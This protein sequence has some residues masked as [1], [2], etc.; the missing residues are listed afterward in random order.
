MYTLKY[1]D[2]FSVPQNPRNLVT[3]KEEKDHAISPDETSPR[4]SDALEKT[5][6]LEPRCGWRGIWDGDGGINSRCDC[7][8]DGGGISSH[9]DCGDCD[10]DRV[11]QRL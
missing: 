11:L 5:A 1:Y 6:P 3:W 4:H 7:W 10:S 2:H 9:G 8:D